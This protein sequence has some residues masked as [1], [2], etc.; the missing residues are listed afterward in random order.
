MKQNKRRGLIVWLYTLKNI[1][2]LQHYGQVYY[3]SRRLKYAVV[4][5]DD[6]SVERVIK[7]L[8]Q[9]H[10]V[11]TVD[12][13]H[14]PEVDMTCAQAVPEKYKEH[15]TMGLLTPADDCAVR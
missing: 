2:R 8:S 6:A 12:I 11:R 14:R 5:V 9:C 10:F 7:E 4:Y 3:V 15:S 13:S 1:T